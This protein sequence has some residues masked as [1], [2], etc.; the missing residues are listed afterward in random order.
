MARAA[1]K[2]EIVH[3]GLRKK[4]IDI[5]K[6]SARQ[7]FDQAMDLAE[8]YLDRIREEQQ[9]AEEAIELVRNR[10]S[11]TPQ[12]EGEY[13]GNFRR[14]QAAAYLQVTIDTLRNWELNGLI[15]VKRRENGYRVYT[16]EDMM[17][18][19]IIRSLRSANYSLAAILRML[20][21]LSNNPNANVK[22][23]INIPEQDEEIISVCDQLIT[24][25]GEAEKNALFVIAQLK[26]L[27]GQYKSS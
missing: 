5:I 21:A 16:P 23:I 7:D 2:V 10:L 4:A 14:K 12:K 24:S 8:D 9:R 19:K 1:L 27:K 26:K 6:L 3:N 22:A 25:L 17:R 11:C 15:T 18:L 13:Q 20:S